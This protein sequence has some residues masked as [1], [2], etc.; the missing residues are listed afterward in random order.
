[1]VPQLQ[2]S[3]SSLG[4]CVGASSYNIIWTPGGLGPFY[5]TLYNILVTQRKNNDNHKKYTDSNEELF[6]FS[7]R[8]SPPPSDNTYTSFIHL[9]VFGM[10]PWSW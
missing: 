2:E 3:Y 8:E 9:G 10:Y 1:M 4:L 7:I 5:I 6:I